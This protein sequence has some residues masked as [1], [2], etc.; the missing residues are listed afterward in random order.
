MKGSG[1]NMTESTPQDIDSLLPS[2]VNV[3]SDARPLIAFY[4]RFPDICI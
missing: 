1:K 3:A 4:S 2:G